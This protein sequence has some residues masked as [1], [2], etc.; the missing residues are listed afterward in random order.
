MKKIQAVQTSP[1]LRIAVKND[2]G[3]ENSGSWS[4]NP[5]QDFVKRTLNLNA[6][7]QSQ[8]KTPLNLKLTR[9]EPKKYKLRN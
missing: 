6:L 3:R 9:L 2:M 4:K 7:T 5:P 8:T 1:V